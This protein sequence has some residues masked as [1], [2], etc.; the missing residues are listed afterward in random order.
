[1]TN[2]IEFTWRNI[3]MGN[4]CGLHLSTAG[5]SNLLHFLQVQV[6]SPPPSLRPTLPTL[7]TGA[8]GQTQLFT[9]V[10]DPGGPLGGQ[11]VAFTTL[12]S[13]N[14]LLTIPTL[15]A[16][17]VDHRYCLTLVVTSRGTLN[18]AASG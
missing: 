1:M 15:N 2:N 14:F 4:P 18:C 5:T 16:A 6:I 7:N 9:L 3:G 17:A 10:K 12:A 13:I 8:I 11:V